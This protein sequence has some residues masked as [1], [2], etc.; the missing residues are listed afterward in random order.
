MTDDA[1]SPNHPRPLDAL[2]ARPRLVPARYDL[3]IPALGSARDATR[4]RPAP[5][6]PPACPAIPTARSTAPPPRCVAPAR[7]CYRR[8]GHPRCATPGAGPAR[9]CGAAAVGRC[10][11]GP[12][13]G[14][15]TQRTVRSAAA[16]ATGR[17]PARASAA[18]A[19]AGAFR[20][21]NCARRTRLAPSIRRARPRA[22][23][24]CMGRSC[25]SRSTSP[26]VGPDRG[27]SS[28]GRPI[29][30]T[31]AGRSTAPRPTGRGAGRRSRR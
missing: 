3:A 6:P 12:T 30:Y 10:A 31:D 26:S 14:R 29:K 20:G 24:R 18:P 23:M 13:G 17:I 1:V 27:H 5:L 19:A 15:G 9:R 11:L 21:S 28:K 4:S 8:C 2:L 25:T 22:R 7:A 16:R